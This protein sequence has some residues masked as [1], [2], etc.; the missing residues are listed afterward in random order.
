M[1]RVFTNLAQNTIQAMPK[2]GSVTVEAHRDY[3]S[4]LVNFSDTGVGIPVNVESKLFMP[5]FT[6]KS[7]GQ[8]FGLVV[9]KWIVE[10]HNGEITYISEA[11]KGTV[12]TVKIPITN[13][14]SHL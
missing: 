5:L 12:F 1:K 14:T 4:F 10:V 6:T 11:G 8:G 2:G 9:C 13:N 3:D 7:K